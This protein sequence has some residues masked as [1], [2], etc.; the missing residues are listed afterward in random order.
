MGEL[1][2]AMNS[3]EGKYGI[4]LF[5]AGLPKWHLRRDN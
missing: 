1:M 2:P 3:A 4:E 5:Q